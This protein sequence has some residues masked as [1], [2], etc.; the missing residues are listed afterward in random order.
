MSWFEKYM[1]YQPVQTITT[2]T[3]WGG[4][5]IINQRCYKCAHCAFISGTPTCHCTSRIVVSDIRGDTCESYLEGG[6]GM[7]ETNCPNYG[8]EQ[9]LKTCHRVDNGGYS[10]RF[11]CSACG[12][13]AIIHNCKTRLDELPKFCP[14][15]GA[16]VI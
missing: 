6:C 14:S 16:K 12:Y 2:T 15:C 3:S 7:S 13:V 5:P 8:V 4:W 1:A 11:E 9:K 10:F